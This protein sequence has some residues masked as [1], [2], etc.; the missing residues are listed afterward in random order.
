MLLGRWLVVLLF[1]FL[2]AIGLFLLLFLVVF[3]TLLGLIVG[4]LL[5][6]FGL[7]VTLGLVILG[8]VVLGLV[9]TLLSL[10]LGLFLLFGVVSRRLVDS[11][12]GSLL[13]DIVATATDGYGRVTRFGI[14]CALI[15]TV[16][17]DR[18]LT[19]FLDLGDLTSWAAA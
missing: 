16:G 10:G 5:A 14:L 13:D 8:L 18:D 12:F 3:L 7:P 4:A 15:A 9:V 19:L 11:D 17:G 6:S 2:L 1:F